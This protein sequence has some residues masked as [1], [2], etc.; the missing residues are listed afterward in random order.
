[1]ALRFDWAQAARHYVDLYQSLRPDVVSGA[2][3]V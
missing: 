3:P 2:E 1:M